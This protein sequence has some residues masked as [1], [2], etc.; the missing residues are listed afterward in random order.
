[1]PHWRK[2]TWAIIVWCA[3]ILVWAIAGG[4]NAANSCSH[5]AGSQYLSAQDAQSACTAG[6]GIGIA[7][8]LLIGFF[9]FVFLSLIWFMTRTRSRDCPVCGSAVKRGLTVCKGCGY[10]FA[11][12]AA[13]PIQAAAAVPP[14]AG[15]GAS[16]RRGG[17]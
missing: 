6:A 13:A 5:Q 4:G 16:T 9:G 11:G 7:V 3:A 2:S 12:T 17:G 15:Y 10:N 14:P 8:I 1:M